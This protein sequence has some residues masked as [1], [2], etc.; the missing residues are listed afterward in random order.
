MVYGHIYKI[1][2]YKTNKVYIGQ[3]TGKPDKRWKDHLKK[4][5]MN[6]HH[7][8]HLQNSFNKH[9]NVFNFQVLNYAAS[10][11][12]LDKL[13]MDYIA[14]YKST[15]QK[16]GYN[17]LIGGGGVRHTPSMKKHKSLLLT[18]N[19]PMKN[20][21]T[22]KKMGETLRNSG[23][24]NGKNNPRY[25]HDIPDASYINFLYADLL[26]TSGDI[27]KLYNTSKEHINRRLKN[28]GSVPKNKPLQN[29]KGLCRLSRY[30]SMH[31]WVTDDKITI[32]DYPGVNFDKRNNRWRVEFNINKEKHK[33]GSFLLK[34]DA[35]QE[36]KRLRKIYDVEEYDSSNKG[37]DNPKYRTDIPD[38]SYLTFLYWDLLLTLNEIAKLYDTHASTIQ[39]R[40]QKHGTVIKSE[41]LRNVKGLCRLSRYN[42]S[43]REVTDAPIIIR[44]YPGVSRHKSGRWAIAFSINKKQR[45]FGSFLLKEDAI[46]ECK[47]LRKEYGVMLP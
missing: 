25:R 39:R 17:I 26:L 11:K 42:F 35:V 36:C 12:A 32:G 27:A 19:N 8:R 6:T 3:T 9:G 15:D 23:I 1:V 10:K 34:E 41:S 33:F 46:F 31:K 18:R 44:D 28:Y 40:L 38:N 5:K 45:K 13:E 30:N 21:E 20:P 43:Y 2:N 37:K 7:S 14:R 4:L 47:R 24:V 22:A 29:T 16:Y